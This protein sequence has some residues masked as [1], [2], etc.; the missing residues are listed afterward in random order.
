VGYHVH[1]S[2]QTEQ[3][4]EALKMALKTRR[5]CQPLVHHPDRGVQYC[6]T[7]YQETTNVMACVVR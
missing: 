7:Y 5:T 1:D 4:S 2:L 6:S 3:V